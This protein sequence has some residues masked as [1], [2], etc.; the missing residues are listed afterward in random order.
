[1]IKAEKLVYIQ[2]NH[3]EEWLKVRKEVDE[4][5]SNKYSMFCVCRKLC[6]GLHEMNCKRFQ[7]EVNNETLK[8]L[9]YLTVGQKV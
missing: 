6:T 9:E 5:V 4:E 1:M 8:R 7:N 2:N 3:F